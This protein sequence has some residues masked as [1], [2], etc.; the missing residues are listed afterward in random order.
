[1]HRLVILSLSFTA[2]IA[3]SPVQ[4]KGVKWMDAAGAGLPAGA[5]M[6]VVSGD[7]TK[8]TNFKVQIKMPA[9]YTVPPHHHPTDEVVRVR[10]G[11]LSYGMGDKVDKSNAGTLTDPKTHVTMQ[12]GMNH[13]VFTSAPALVE[14]TGMGPFQIVYVDPK[15]DPRNK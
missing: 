1:M 15:D 5:K 2:L 4:S 8:A 13:W 12:A 9:D 3:V 6:A 10:S 14:V 7:P 11:S